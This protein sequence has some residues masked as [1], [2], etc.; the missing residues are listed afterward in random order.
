MVNERDK[1]TQI[2]GRKKGKVL[3]TVLAHRNGEQNCHAESNSTKMSKKKQMGRGGGGSSSTTATPTN[4]MDFKDQKMDMKSIMKDIESLV[5]IYPAAMLMFSYASTVDYHF[6]YEVPS[7]MTW[8]ERKELEN[9]KVVALGGKPP[10]KQ[11]LPL[12]VA[13]VTMKK[14]KERDQKTLQE[15]LILGRFG[16]KLG[17]GT[18][19]VGEKRKREDMVLKSTEGHFRN[20]VLDVKRLMKQSAPKERDINTYAFDNE[21]K[22][23]KGGKKNQGKKKGGG[24]KRH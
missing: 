15:N 5:V 21:G 6:P 23:K 18:K 24:K 22:K 9:R 8:R 20:G 17:N 3:A 16:A 19:K 14:Q 13:R 2:V 1:E 11:R 7:H 12:S 4:Y 10:K